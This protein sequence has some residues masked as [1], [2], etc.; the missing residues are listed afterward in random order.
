MDDHMMEKVVAY[1]QGKA[2]Y[3]TTCNDCRNYAPG[4]RSAQ[5]EYV[6]DPCM[7][8]RLVG[9]ELHMAER[10]RAEEFLA[11]QRERENCP[12]GDTPLANERGRM[13]RT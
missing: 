3:H 1:L 9:H 7:M 11:R 5:G 12:P 4:T 10:D 8:K 2:R 13:Y 6:C